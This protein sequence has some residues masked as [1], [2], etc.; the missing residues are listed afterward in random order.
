[1]GKVRN[2]FR[3]GN[4][5]AGTDN[6]R[7]IREALVLLPPGVSKVYLR[8]DTAGYQHDLMKFC[9][10]PNKEYGI[11][12]FAI[13]AKV[14]EAFK[15]AVSEVE[16]S[17]WRRLYRK[18]EKGLVA[19]SQ[20]YAEVCF[21]PSE[22]A[23]KKDGPE[24]RYLAVREV[25]EQPALPEMDQQLSLPFP[26]M[27]FCSVKYKVFGIV[28]NRDIPGDELIWWHRERCGKSEEAHSVMKTLRGGGSHRVVLA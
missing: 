15:R 6:V 17:E 23:R 20:E 2:E 22:L 21:V 12:E 14:T 27:D 8:E 16:S 28:T 26:T 4:V 24:F 19:T 7:I 10:D 1:L 13:G 9:A 5:W 18:T 3:Y 11:I 25:L